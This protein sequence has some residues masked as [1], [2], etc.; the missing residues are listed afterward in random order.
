MRASIY[1]HLLDEATIDTKEYPNTSCLVFKDEQFNETVIFASD[2]KLEEIAEVIFTFLQDK[3]R[4]E[5]EVK[6]ANKKD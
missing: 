2:E 3:Q 6:D 4:R 5:R 1:L